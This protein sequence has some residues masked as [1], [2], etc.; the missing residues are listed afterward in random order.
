MHDRSL[1]SASKLSGNRLVRKED[2][3]LIASGWTRHACVDEKGEITRIPPDLE[4]VLKA[5]LSHPAK[6]GDDKQSP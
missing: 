3:V 4:N 2:G 1:S 5:A 6:P